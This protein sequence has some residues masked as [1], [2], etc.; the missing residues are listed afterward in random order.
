[1]ESTHPAPNRIVVRLAAWSVTLM[2]A[3]VLLMSVLALLILVIIAASIKIPVDLPIDIILTLPG[4]IY[5]CLLTYGISALKLRCPHC[6]YKFLKA[7]KGLWPGNSWGHRIIRCART[8]QIRC[9]QCG[10][11]IFS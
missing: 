2:W 8:G 5:V 6:A 9:I 7:P 4:V 11:E 10:E 3:L 1:M